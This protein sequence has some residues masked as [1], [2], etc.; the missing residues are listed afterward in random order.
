MRRF[1]LVGAVVVGAL[2]G[3]LLVRL[4]GTRQGMAVQPA[5][6]LA[7]ACPRPLSQASGASCPKAGLSK[8]NPSPCPGKPSAPA[9]DSSFPTPVYDGN[10]E[11]AARQDAGERRA[12]AFRALVR[13]WSRV[14]EKSAQGTSVSSSVRAANKASPADVVTFVAAFGAV[15][16]P[17]RWDCLRNALNLIPDGNLSLLAGLTLDKTQEPEV[18]KEVFNE[19]VNRSE[20]AKRPILEAVAAD[21]THPCCDDATW[22]FEV[23]G[24]RMGNAGEESK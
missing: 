6:C 21:K 16:P 23:T 18:R 1:L 13:K 19:I 22:I 2:T 17:W 11:Q 20:E 15:P 4:T 24:E 12:G 10:P 7:K 3:A 8:L 9:A 14:R 5:E